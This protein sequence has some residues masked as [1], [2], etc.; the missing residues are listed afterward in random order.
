MSP[1]NVSEQLRKDGNL[2]DDIYI[3]DADDQPKSWQDVR[4]SVN[5]LLHPETADKQQLVDEFKKDEAAALK[6]AK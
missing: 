5:T 6:N 1:T 4:N 2:R 3:A